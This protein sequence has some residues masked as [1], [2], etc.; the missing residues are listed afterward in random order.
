MTLSLL[1]AAPLQGNG[2]NKDLPSV[3]CIQRSPGQLRT[4]G[5]K[6][7]YFSADLITCAAA[8][9]ASSAHFQ[10][11]SKLILELQYF[12][13]AVNESLEFLQSIYRGPNFISLSQIKF[14]FLTLIPIRNYFFVSILDRKMK[15]QRNELS[16]CGRKNR[17]S[18]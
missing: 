12:P 18:F 10:C 6:R 13:V 8:A 2:A 7:G 15:P 5:K 16:C 11:R 14:Y 1:G 9:I 3:A 4:R 17:R